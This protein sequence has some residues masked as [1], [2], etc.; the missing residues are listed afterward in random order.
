MADDAHHPAAALAQAFASAGEAAGG[1]ARF[2]I[3]A[4]LDAA[5]RAAPGIE[6]DALRDVVTRAAAEAARA[7]ARGRRDA[8]ASGER[9]RRITIVGGEGAMGRFFGARMRAQGHQVRSLD[10][11]DWD[12]AP[13]LL[14]DADLALLC[15][16]IDAMGGVMGRAAGHLRAGALLADVCSLKAEPVRAMLEAHAGPV[17]GLHPM[18]GP[19]V[20]S[21]LSQRVVVCPGRNGG[22][23][24]WLLE[25]LEADGALLTEATP[26]EHDRMM[27]VVQAMRHFATIVFGRFLAEEG[28]DAARS[29]DF[30]SPV[31][32]L[33]LGMVERLF[34]QDAA[35]YAD[36]ILADEERRAAAGRLAE[37]ARETAA[38]VGE[39][40]RAGLIALFRSIGERL[41]GEPERAL[42]ESAGAIDALGALLAA[43][44]LERERS[45]GT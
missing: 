24:R 11:G 5:E 17:I 18:F 36:I 23:A 37:A 27:L 3:E 41:R 19:G 34:A 14:G 26:E 29:L 39:A 21:M 20:G 15:A 35:L 43:Q 1:D 13:E 40:D 42:I 7:R 33:E 38:L 12:R 22:A 2:S 6:R 8:A 44:R 16:P 9:G 4:W 30:A 31:Y 10:R 25:A 28:V 45:G 32:R